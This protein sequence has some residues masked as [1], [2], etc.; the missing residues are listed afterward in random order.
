MQLRMS[1]DQD[2]TSTLQKVADQ[3]GISKAR[4]CSA[5]ITELAEQLTHHELQQ[6]SKNINVLFNRK[7][8]TK[9]DIMLDLLQTHGHITSQRAKLHGIEHP[10]QM[11]HQLRMSGHA[12]EDRWAKKN[13]RQSENHKIYTYK[14]QT[15]CIE[16]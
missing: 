4:L 13:V 15:Q 10:G 1:I 6:A 12:I 5:L 8:T 14:G 7:K 9:K 3:L 16:H 11:I 2:T